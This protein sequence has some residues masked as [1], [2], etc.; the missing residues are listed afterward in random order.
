MP[1]PA[2]FA[3]VSEEKSGNVTERG[4]KINLEH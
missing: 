3:T 4:K 1:L 2:Q